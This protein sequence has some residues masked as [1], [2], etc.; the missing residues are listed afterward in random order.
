MINSNNKIALI[1]LFSI[2]NALAYGQVKQLNNTFTSNPF[3]TKKGSS[4]QS[5][6]APKIN[7][8][9][10]KARLQIENYYGS[11]YVD[12]SEENINVEKVS[13]DFNSWFNLDN[14]HSFV[15]LSSKTDELNLTHNYYQQYYKGVL[16]EGAILML[17]ANKGIVYASNGQVAQFEKIDVNPIVSVENAIVTAKEYLK[18]TDLINTYPVETIIAKIPNGVSFYFKFAHKVRIESVNPNIQA[19]IYI[20]ACKDIVINSVSLIENIDTPISVTTIYNGSQNITVD[21]YASGFRLKDNLRKIETYDGTNSTQSSP[22]YSGF[23][24]ISSPTSTWN[25]NLILSD[26]FI[27]DCSDNWWK[28]LVFDPKPE[29]YIIVKNASNQI[30]YN[31]NSNYKINTRPPFVFNMPSLTLSPT[32]NY[33][34]ELW[35]YDDGIVS[36]DDFGG[37][38]QLDLSPGRH[39]WSCNGNNGDYYIVSANAALDV[40]WGM[41]KSYDYFKNTHQRNSFDGNNIT[42]KSYINTPDKQT[43]YPGGDAN[44]SGFKRTYDIFSFG[45]GD[46]ILLNPS[47]SLD[48]VGH[49]FTHGVVKYRNSSLGG[50]SYQGQS[51]ALNESFADI[52]ATCI[53]FETKPST[54]NWNIGEGI[55]VQAGGFDRSMSNPNLKNQP[56]TYLSPL[57]NGYWDSSANPKVHINSGVQNYWFYLLS[58]GGSGTNDLGNFYSVTG[59]GINKARKIAYLN[60]TTYLGSST[61]TYTDS[62]NGSLLAAQ[63]LYGNPSPE[64]NAVKNAWYAVGLGSNPLNSCT[65]TT[66]LTASSGTFTDGSGLANYD[67]NSSCIWVIAPPGATQINLNFTAF[68]T[69]VTVDKVIVYNGPDDTYP[70]L[71]TW[72]G[73]VLPP[74]ISTTA[75]VG[76][77]CIKF[78]TNTSNTFSGWS[79]N[80]TSLITDPSCEGITMLT[81]PSG[82]FS[83]G[84]GTNNY[85][86]NQQCL[87]Y[88][89]PPCATSITLSFT[90]FNTELNND[91]VAIY[92]SL[93][94][95]TP[96]AAFTGTSLPAS[97]TSTT[98]VMIV[99]FISDY[100]IS[101][102]GFNANYTSTGSSFC[103][104]T[105]T[106]NSSD[107]GTISD[108]SGT[109]NYCNNSNCS[110]L[111]QPP[112]ATSVTLN[113]AAFNLEQ[114]SSD[115]NSIYDVVEVYDG[116]SSSSPLLG[117]FAGSNIP[118]AVT[119]SSGSMFVKF[120]SD[121]SG[122]YQGW[123]AYY[124][125]TQNSYC[126]SSTS[127]L[128]ASSG[129]FTDGSGIDKYANN[130]NC[131]WLIQPTNATSITL[132]FTLFD[133]ELN[134]DGVIVYDGANS[135]API[136]G[137]FTGSTLPNSI[138]STGG[139]MYFVFLSDEALRANGW[140]ANYTSTNSS[141]PTT[142][143]FDR[144]LIDSAG[145]T[146]TSG[147][148][149]ITW[150]L[151]EPIIGNMT[152]GN[153]K[154]TNGFHPLLNT[155]ALEIQ[156]HSIDLTVI[157]SPNP[158]NDFLNIF[159]KQNHDLKVSV[160][161]I[162]GKYIMQETLNF[163]DNKMDVSKLSEGVYIIYV[164]DKQTQ[165]TNTYK[166]IKN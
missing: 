104:G 120:T 134:Y 155:Q 5:V 26:V 58:Q 91:G 87:W 154:L 159:Q 150:S 9:I 96:I 30:I 68:N 37:S 127:T 161:D 163:Q 42:I 131:S 73:N 8:T 103:S 142:I 44:N 15:L 141:N 83:D 112:N 16:I 123:T 72:W 35:E 62:F 28:T 133:T 20:D 59:I 85:T 75:G 19:D 46:G 43:R 99:A 3:Q 12:L 81:T 21:S 149:V 69:E 40:H 94:A 98:G 146:Q 57:P 151:G 108:G 157:I 34:I 38:F 24:E 130:S 166:I 135:S 129:T 148:T 122:T 101:L 153:I 31:G 11:F 64:Y 71:A 56:D 114:T 4:S 49:E 93:T 121:I 61:A 17:H 137:Q 139:S 74:T 107:Y 165:K 76:A 90:S 125:S 47:V 50:L 117:K 136:I 1:V 78:T 152:S 111:I 39:S 118:S 41:E 144:K 13:K 48:I 63:E 18:V 147:S 53:E 102:Q 95:T 119:S 7:D 65:G 66:N 162:S 55:Y 45:L 27:L 156:D 145:N 105:T 22:I 60:L 51:G 82:T 77:M 36:P 29:F 109:N 14:S 79:A 158:T 164:Q 89:A 32:S 92:D 2:F 67:N 110:W 160:F 116:T 128:T 143:N 100:S 138:T 126:N 54:A 97:V 25:N 80:Y 115:G 124:T 33:T 106:L 88:I 52:F 23:S 132:S 86:N 140:S 70:V 6:L 113:F 84:S 10:K